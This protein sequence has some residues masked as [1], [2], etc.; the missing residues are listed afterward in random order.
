MA[1]LK[2]DIQIEGESYL[3]NLK[4]QTRVDLYLFY[5]EC[6]VNISRHSGAT[7][8]KTRLIAGSKQVLLSINDNGRGLDDKLEHIPKSLQ[9]RANPLGATVTV[10]SPKSGGTSISLSLPIRTSGYRKNQKS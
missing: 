7:E 6:L 10:V 3:N 1:K 9:R 2:H 8:F 5:K 4:Q